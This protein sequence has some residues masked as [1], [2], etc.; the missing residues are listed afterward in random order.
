VPPA[1]QPAAAAA[2]PHD[3]AV[4]DYAD[5]GYQPDAKPR[6][7]LDTE[8]HIRAA[9]AFIHMPHNAAR[10]APGQLAQVKAR[11]VTAWRAHIDRA[12][13]PEISTPERAAVPREPDTARKGLWLAERLHC[14][15]TDLCD[16]IET[17]EEHAPLP[18]LPY[19]LSPTGGEGCGEGADAVFGR[20]HHHPSAAAAAATLSRDAGEGL[21]AKLADAIVPRLDALQRRVEDIAQTPLPP[22]T[23][24]RG[25]FASLAKRDDGSSAYGI[26]PAPDDIVAAL[27]RMSDEERTLTLIK[28][29]HA[30]P[31]RR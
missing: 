7:P 5:P 17:L 29:A 2:D 3:T 31:I 6:Y 19:P 4:A 23:V 21:L 13:P 12:G 25:S 24:A 10:Y 20:R 9:W 16:L 22:Q 14:I 15:V 26:P 1:P 8:R 11:I 28:A 30:A 18:T 27:A